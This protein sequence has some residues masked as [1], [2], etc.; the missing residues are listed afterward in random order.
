MKNLKNIAIILLQLFCFN[1]N[2]Q[3][4]PKLTDRNE[5]LETARIGMITNRLDLSPEQATVFWPI[6]NEYENKKKAIKKELRMH[7]SESRSVAANDDKI[8]I[9]LN[10]MLALR[11]KE[12][13]LE[14]EYLP[15]FMKVVKPRQVSELYRTE[16]M[17][18]QMLLRRMGG[19]GLHKPNELE[20]NN[21]QNHKYKKKQN[22][23]R[24]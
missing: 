8:K 19:H 10:E 20:L 3:E 21:G 12:V 14:K 11:Q 13:D 5:K 7:L 23:I 4:K 2:A 15:K 9:E 16:Q 22:Q 18:K 6:Y 17:F 24:E 1:A